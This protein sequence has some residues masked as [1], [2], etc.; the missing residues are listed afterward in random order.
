MTR[1]GGGYGQGR[2]GYPWWGEVVAKVGE[3][4]AR[5]GDGGRRGPNEN[6]RIREPS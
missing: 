5:V 3:V 6:R 4:M 2:G 1:V